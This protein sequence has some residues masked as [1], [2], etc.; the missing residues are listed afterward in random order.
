MLSV[1]KTNNRILFKYYIYEE[2]NIFYL[3]KSIY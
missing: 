3:L 1:I 2:Q